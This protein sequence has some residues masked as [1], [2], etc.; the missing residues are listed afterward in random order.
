[1]G[2]NGTLQK[3]QIGFGLLPNSQERGVW[4]PARNA[5]GETVSS[6]KAFRNKNFQCFVGAGNPPAEA[7]R[8]IVE[9]EGE[10]AFQSL[11]NLLRC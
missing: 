4:L 6:R 5:A 9:V 10:K 2:A 3:I 7:V 11:R 8:K 1:M